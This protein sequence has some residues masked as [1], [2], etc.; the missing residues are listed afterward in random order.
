[1]IVVEVAPGH[2]SA[3]LE[4]PDRIVSGRR[5]HEV[6]RLVVDQLGVLWSAIRDGLGLRPY[7]WLTADPNCLCFQE[8][9]EPFLCG[10]VQVIPK[11][12]VTP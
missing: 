4:W 11:T 5:L 2:M 12:V 6:D 9:E 10:V 7:A 1:M 3:R 8:A